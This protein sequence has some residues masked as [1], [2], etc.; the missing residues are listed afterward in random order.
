MKRH[1]TYL[2]LA[3]LSLLMVGLLGC[4]SRNA[5][6]QT[7]AA[8]DQK[9]RDEV[10]NATAKVKEESR[11]AAQDL[12]AAAR[13]AKHEAKV[14]AE[15]VKEGWNRDSQGRLNLNLATETQLRDL[16]GMTPDEARKV[17][18]NRPYKDKQELVTRG[19]VSEREYDDIE[20]QITV[21]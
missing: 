5:S 12:D 15:G 1:V 21:P 20:N 2:A 16:P 18:D 7:Q 13:Q 14:A 9:T 10:A 4:T 6:S 17:I 11:V 19:I 3:F 8:Q